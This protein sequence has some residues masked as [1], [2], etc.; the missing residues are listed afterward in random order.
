MSAKKAVKPI[1]PVTNQQNLSLSL[2][3]WLASDD[4]Y[5]LVP[6][7]KV[8]SATTLIKPIR[9]LALSTVA[10]KQNLI[11]PMDIEHKVASKV[12]SAVH[13]AVEQSWLTNLDRAMKAL[14][15]SEDYAQR[16]KINPNLN[17]LTDEDLPVYIEQR[18][19][20]T[21][22]S[23]TISGKFDFVVGGRVEDIKTTKC[24]KYDRPDAIE[25]YSKQGS[26]YRWIF[27]DII[28]YPTIMINYVL[29]DWVPME[30]TRNQ[31]PP[32]KAVSKE[33]PLMTPEGTEA[34]I[35]ERLR[36]LEMALQQVELDYTDQSKLPRC[37]PAELW[38]GPSIWAYYKNPQNTG[39]STKNYKT[40][41]EAY[42]RLAE[43]GN[44]GRVEERIDIPSRC[45]FCAAKPLCQQAQEYINL[46]LITAP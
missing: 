28:T 2:A 8:I 42:N 23:W 33:Y 29:M 35:E 11:E 19:E 15:Y 1:E 7:E 12:G 3:V 26:V 39:K 43:D 31:K 27:S 46:G 21:I 4:D 5:D 37:T 40:S 44:V 38:Q 36:L 17:E 16:I 30:A 6:E 45:N 9:M 13:A 32:S 34:W 25:E 10:Q 24:F 14:D 18:G 20:R 22:G 41:H